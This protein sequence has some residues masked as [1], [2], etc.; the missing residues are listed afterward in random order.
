MQLLR[1]LAQLTKARIAFLGALSAG[2]GA[3][4]RDSEALAAAATVA[5]GILLLACGACALNEY[6]ERHLDRQMARTASRPLALGTVRLQH[7]A[8]LIAALLGLGT[9]TLF[10]GCGALPAGLGVAAAVWYNAVYT[11]LKRRTAFAAIPGA[12]IGAVPPAVGWT[13]AGGSLLSPALWAIGLFFFLW[14]VPHFWLLLLHHGEDY[15]RAGL[16]SL[17]TRLTAA[18]LARTTFAW[19]VAA[20]VCCLLIPVYA[21]VHSYL[22]VWVLLGAGL[23]LTAAAAELLKLPH[24]P[25]PANFGFRQMNLY[26]GV[27]VCT[28]LLTGALRP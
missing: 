25:L 12:L 15:Q 21:S 24:Q 13:A 19:I 10:L 2:M 26:A 23:W 6:Q 17:T 16:P 22:L 1:S 14:Q 4:L 11:P 27:V 18:Q 5:G 7:A 8:A 9:V 20:A 28:L 3:L